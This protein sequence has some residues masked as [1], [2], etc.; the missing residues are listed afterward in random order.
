[1]VSQNGNTQKGHNGHVDPTMNP[2][3]VYF[4]HPFDNSQKIV[5]IVFAGRG[6]SNWKR[7]MTIALSGRNKLG[8]VDDSLSRPN[9]NSSARALDRVDNVVMRWIIGVLEN[10][11]ANSILSFKTCKEI[12]DELEERY[13]Q[14]SNAQ[15]FSLQEEL[16]ALVQ[17][18]KMSISE[19]FTKI[20]T[21]WDEFDA[22]NPIPT[23]TYT[24]AANCTCDVAKKVFK[25]Q[26][27]NKF[28]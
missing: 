15:M 20:K 13:G 21:L 9:N 28:Y 1:M 25:M 22:L 4:L 26:L 17:T 12:W 18:T 19:F 16:N 11:I 24:A 10:S 6:F 2:S 3:S 7:V 23:C 27:N 14:S 8:F 5:N